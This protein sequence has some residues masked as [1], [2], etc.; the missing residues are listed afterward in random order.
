MTDEQ[1]IKLAKGFIASFNNGDWESVE[2]ALCP[3]V[4]YTEIPTKTE[5]IGMDKFVELCKI[6]KSIMSDC[7]GEVTNAHASGDTVILEITWTG[8]QSGPMQTPLGEHPSSSK[9][10]KTNGVQILEIGNEKITIIKNHFDL[11]SML[12]QFGAI[13]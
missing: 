10:Q 7:S 13:N 3:E 4:N 12:M 9:F 8:T 6:W 2:G 11:L 1:K 5:I